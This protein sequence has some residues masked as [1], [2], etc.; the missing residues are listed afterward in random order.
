MVRTLA[1]KMRPCRCSS[2]CRRRSRAAASCKSRCTLSPLMAGKKRKR[3]RSPPGHNTPGR[4]GDELPPPPRA[5][6]PIRR[7][8]TAAGTRPVAALCVGRWG[9]RWGGR[10]F[11][12]AFFWASAF[13]LTLR[14]FFLPVPPSRRQTIKKK[15]TRWFKI[16]VRLKFEGEWPPHPLPQGWATWSC[17]WWRTLSPGVGSSLSAPSWDS[18]A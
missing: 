1:L 9:A 11:G 2:R 15:N 17:W 3:R 6:W 12:L 4:H 16:C 18:T 7:G 13:H 8:C 5:R 10:A 14:A